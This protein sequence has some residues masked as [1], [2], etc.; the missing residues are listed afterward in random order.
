MPTIP[1]TTSREEQ[2]HHR[3]NTSVARLLPDTGSH[4]T[5]ELLC[6]LDTNAGLDSHCASYLQVAR[7]ST[8]AVAAD[9]SSR[10]PCFPAN[11]GTNVCNSARSQQAVAA[12]SSNRIQAVAARGRSIGKPPA[13]PRPVPIDD[14]YTACAF[15]ECTRQPCHDPRHRKG[16]AGVVRVDAGQRPVRPSTSA[17][18]P[19]S[20]PSCRVTRSAAT[21]LFDNDAV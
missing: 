20:G 8:G 6:P 11:A 1:T 18:Q 15:H 19:S 12:T 2:P 16:D 10:R 9:G 13:R 14:R 4:K 7:S 3:R 17:R 21:V 5:R